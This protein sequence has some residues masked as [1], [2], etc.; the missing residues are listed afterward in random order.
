M[1]KVTGRL[2]AAMAAGVLALGFSTVGFAQAPSGVFNNVFDLNAAGDGAGGYIY[3]EPY[4]DLAGGGLSGDASS[5]ALAPNTG[6]YAAV[7]PG[8]AFWCDNAGAGP[9]GNKW[10]E[11]SMY[12]EALISASGSPSVEMFAACV[13]TS[14]LAAP[15]EVTTAFIK[16][17]STSFDLFGEVYGPV[18][19]E[20]SI[21]VLGDVDVIVQKGFVIQGPNANP[22]ADTGAAIAYIGATS[23]PGSGFGAGGS[24]DPRAIPTLPLWA[25]FGLTAIVGLIGSRKLIRRG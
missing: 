2:F 5:W 9:G 6:Y 7:C 25:L 18:C 15:Y 24:G 4:G 12:S 20:L 17:F 8:D 23:L 13:D 11:A 21:D 22:A 1:M 3:S 19:G 14:G 10:V 16:V